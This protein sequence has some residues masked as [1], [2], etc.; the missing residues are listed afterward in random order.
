MDFNKLSL[1]YKIAGI[2]GIVAVIGMFLPWVSVG[3]YGISLGVV[4]GFQSGGIWGILVFLG[5]LGC[6]ALAYF[7]M[8]GQSFFAQQKKMGLLIAG[9]VAL[10]GALISLLSALSVIGY[11]GIGFWLCLIASAV[12]A[13]FGFMEYQKN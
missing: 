2:A 5:A 11:L 13:Y 10:V 12:M 8:S 9:G 3:A 4:S 7:S 1:N 6:I